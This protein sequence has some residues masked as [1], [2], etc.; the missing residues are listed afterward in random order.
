MHSLVLRRIVPYLVAVSFSSCTKDETSLSSSSPPA[1]ETATDSGFVIRH[2]YIELEK[3][4]RISKFRSGI[5]HDYSDDSEDC[6]SMK[7]YYQP[8]NSV[9]WSSVKI[10]SPVSGTVVRIV[11]EWAGTQVQIQPFIYS[12]YTVIIFHVAVQRSL[13]VGDTVTAGEQLGT[14]AG[15][16]TMSDIAIGF[17]AQNQWRLVSY[18]DL[19]SDSLFQ[20]YR[21]RGIVSRNDLIITKQARDADPLNCNGETFGTEGTLSNWGVLH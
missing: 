4:D 10:F 1:K 2:E 21:Q 8:K 16:Q 13:A 20:Q 18:F 11:D 14:H 3:I 6:R 19:I 17:S 7:H 5:G 12:S 15:V 9:T